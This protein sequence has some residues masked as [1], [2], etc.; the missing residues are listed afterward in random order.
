MKELIPIVI[1]AYEP[2]ERLIMLLEELKKNDMKPVIVVDDGSGEQYAD[3][4]LQAEKL[5][6]EYGGTLLKHTVNCGKGRALKTGFSYILQHMPAAIGCVTAD[7]DGQH[8]VSCIERVQQTLQNNSMNLILGVRDFDNENI[9]WKGQFGNTVT[10]KVFAY[11]AGIHVTD[12]QTGLRGIPRAFMESLLQVK[13]E[14]FEF[15]TQMLLESRK[16]FPI[17]EVKIETIYESKDNHQTHFRP[18]VD[19]WKIYRILG[20]QFFCF[21]ISSLSSSVIDIAL[22]ALFCMLFKQRIPEAYVAVSTAIARIISATY[23]YIINYKI[24]FDSRKQHSI[25][26]GKYILL[27]VCQM[28]LSAGLVTGGTL[29][30]SFV[31]EVIV[32]IIVDTALFFVSYHIQQRYV[33]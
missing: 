8:T 25:S 1:P 5:V 10:E 14:R 17:K 21:I 27:A 26:V 18:L 3:V 31:P 11:V 29:L 19:S 6:T 24:V 23:N 33:F 9:P 15:E 16:Q 12:T 7:S 20:K 4:F 22:F 13:G 32:K 30:L 28:A 2:D